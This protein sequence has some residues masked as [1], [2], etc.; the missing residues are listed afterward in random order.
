MK[1]CF[2]K[3]DKKVPFDS[4]YRIFGTE[5]LFISNIEEK[6]E[7]NKSQLKILFS[8]NIENN[9]LIFIDI[10][11]K[12]FF[13]ELIKDLLNDKI[14][15]SE[16]QKPSKFSIKELGIID[17]NDLY[18]FYDQIELHEAIELKKDIILS[19]NGGIN[20]PPGI[21]MLE[22]EKP[23]DALQRKMDEIMQTPDGIDCVFFATVGKKGDGLVMRISNE[24][25]NPE[26]KFDGNSVNKFFH[27]IEN[28]EVIK[29]LGKGELD[30]ALFHFSNKQ[31]NNG[32]ILSISIVP[33]AHPKLWLGFVSA[34]LGLFSRF[35]AFQEDY[36]EEL[37]KLSHECMPEFY[38]KK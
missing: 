37:H 13:F 10:K 7:N 16:I 26:Q 21:N 34:K 30:F 28:I 8:G 6:I 2:Y 4:F 29:D 35:M 22:V 18:L 17:K 24:H 5:S 32:G 14:K 25:P 19:N 33:D 27:A 38:K 15:W 12:K 1:I 20:M 36:L 31:N 11:L 3:T 9:T 23:D